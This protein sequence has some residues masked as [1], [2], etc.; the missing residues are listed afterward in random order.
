M[1]V[2]GLISCGKSKL[3]HA[4]PARE[5]Y[6]GALFKKARAYVERH[7]DEWAILSAKHGLVDPQAMIDP[8]ELRLPSSRKARQGWAKRVNAQVRERWPDARIIVLAG[9]DYRCAFEGELALP[10][11][12]PMVGLGLGEQLSWLSRS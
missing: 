1:R 12:V 10:I 2:V 8:Y 5:L 9:K 6:T 11:E 3:A 4:A 7:C